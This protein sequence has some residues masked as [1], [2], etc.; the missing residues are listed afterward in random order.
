VG[1]AAL[2]E[3]PP[4]RGHSTLVCDVVAGVCEKVMQFAAAPGWPAGHP[5]SPVGLPCGLFAEAGTPEPPGLSEVQNDVPGLWQSGFFQLLAGPV[6]VLCAM[7]LV[8]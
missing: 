1:T 8:S 3:N 7:V 2:L 5:T 4:E 6:P